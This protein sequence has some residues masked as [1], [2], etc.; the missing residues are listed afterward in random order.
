MGY[1]SD[2]DKERKKIHLLDYTFSKYIGKDDKNSN[3]KRK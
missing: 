3:N 2:F 1:R